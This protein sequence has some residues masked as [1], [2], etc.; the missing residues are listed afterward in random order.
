MLI[1]ANAA[2]TSASGVWMEG[3]ARLSGKLND[4][5]AALHI[6]EGLTVI[7]G[8]LAVVRIHGRRRRRLGRRHDAQRSVTDTQNILHKLLVPDP[9]LEGADNLLAFD[10]LVR[11]S[12]LDI[13][14]FPAPELNSRSFVRFFRPCVM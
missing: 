11:L 2:L 14:L 10:S 3:T 1:E 7:G 6:H 5:R 8:M 9:S 13:Q 4:E 12:D